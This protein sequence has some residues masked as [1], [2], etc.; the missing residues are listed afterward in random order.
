MVQE[1][2]F[3]VMIYLKDLALHSEILNVLDKIQRAIKVW[4]PDCHLLVTYITL[5]AGE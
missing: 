3:T 2:Q 4:S 5:E 1:D